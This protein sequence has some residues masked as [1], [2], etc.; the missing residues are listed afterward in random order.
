MRGIDPVEAYLCD[1]GLAR[2]CT[3][4]YKKP[5]TNNIKDIYMHLTNFSVNKNSLRYKAP[6]E[7]FFEDDKSSKQLFTTA[8]KKLIS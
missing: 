5:D 8:I 4:N 7:Q 6:G 2:F 3:H 1:E